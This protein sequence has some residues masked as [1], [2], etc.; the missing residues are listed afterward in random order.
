[1]S[2]NH[3]LLAKCTTDAVLSHFKSGNWSCCNSIGENFYRVGCDTTFPSP[4]AAFYDDTNKIL[5][6]FEFKP[7]T[8]TKRG[9]L[10]G[11]GQSIAYLNFSNFSFLIIPQYIEDFRIGEYMEDLYSK[12][13]QQNLPIGLIVYDNNNPQDVKLTHKIITQNTDI[14]SQ[15]NPN[16]RFWAKHVDLPIPL[17]H[18]LLHCFYMNK[19]GLIN[20]DAFKY[21]WNHHLI[22]KDNL[23]KLM[24]TPV[25][26]IYDHQPIKTL[27]ERKNILYFE[28]KIN[29]IKQANVSDREA[30]ID[31]LLHS[32]DSDFV[33][34]NMY[35]SIRK[36]FLPF[37]RHLG[38]IDSTN[39]LTEAGFKLYHLGITH[40]PSS[41]MFYDYF[42]KTVLL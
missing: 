31:D 9:I 34:D 21:C 18:L 24:P 36:N 41:K 32:A 5:A 22:N 3:H 37:L 2:L 38:M 29:K 16:T 1:M 42:T 39:T 25:L 14:K 30:M 40:G 20:E 27:G 11:L 17:F 19:I 35:N 15:A 8:E 23:R 7:P 13:I 10:T 26:N 33:G 4:D 6:T 12:K 28:K